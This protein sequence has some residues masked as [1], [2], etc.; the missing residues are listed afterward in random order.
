MFRSLSVSL[1]DDNASN[2]WSRADGSIVVFDEIE[3]PYHAN[4]SVDDIVE[5]QKPFIN[6]H[7]LTVGDL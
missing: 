1:E 2:H 7:N 6:R 4:A 3:T 5:S